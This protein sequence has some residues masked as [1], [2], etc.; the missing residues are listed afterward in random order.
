[1][2]LPNAEQA[3][4]EM[5]Q[6][7]GYVL[8]TANPSGRSKALFLLRFGF[9]ADAWEVLAEALKRRGNFHDVVRTVETVHGSRY[10]VDG[11]VDTSEA[12]ATVLPCQA[13]PVTGSDITH[14]RKVEITV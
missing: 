12:I 9:T 4:V 10:Y 13:R 8:S 14:A 11:I 7:T 2:R 6:I 5:E 3:F 1:M